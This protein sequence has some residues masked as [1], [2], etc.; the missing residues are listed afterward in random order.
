MSLPHYWTSP[1][2]VYDVLLAA[3]PDD[4]PELLADIAIHV[5]DERDA[6]RDV[7]VASL[8]Q[9]HTL[10]ERLDRARADA[11]RLRDAL[12]AARGSDREAA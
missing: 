5:M 1:R 4:Q 6:L 3:D 9:L 2:K 8:E 10:S 12:R 11:A 7:L